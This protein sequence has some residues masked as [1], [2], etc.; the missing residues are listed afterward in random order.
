MIRP[1]VLLL[2]LA[3]LALASPAGA[4]V[5]YEAPVTP[6]QAEPRPTAPTPYDPIADLLSSLPPDQST[7]SAE[8]EPEVT[9]REEQEALL[10]APFT[11]GAQ[12]TAPILLPQTPQAIP[13]IATPRRPTPGRPTLDRPVMIDETDRSPDS[14]PTQIDLGYEARVRGSASSAQG[15]QGPLDGG[16]TV[17]GPDGAALYGLQLVDRSGGALEGAWRALGGSGRVGLIESLE[18]SGSM[19]TVRINR[20]Y[21][22]PLTVLRL[23]AASNGGWVGDITDEAGTRAVT[24]RRN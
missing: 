19:L 18:R 12:P 9:P 3:T 7:D 4:Q 1:G 13:P 24:M 11:P 6:T 16:W 5:F 2:L 8:A 15:L 23:S 22:R 21:G 20:G 10:T 14:P 17:R